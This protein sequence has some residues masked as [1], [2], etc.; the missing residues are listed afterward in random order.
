MKRLIALM[1]LV[2]VFAVVLQLLTKNPV[3][4]VL[5]AVL[6]CGALYL[7][8]AGNPSFFSGLFADMMQSVSVFDRF[9]AFTDGVFDLTAVIYYLS[10]ICVFLFLTVQ[11]MEKRRWNE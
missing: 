11:S 5:A 4:S 8:Y 7:W 3:I 1:L 2:V 6:G 10:I 9:D